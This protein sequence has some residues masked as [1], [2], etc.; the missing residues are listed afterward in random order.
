M[1][2]AP[3]VLLFSA[4]ASSAMAQPT[5]PGVVIDHQPAESRQYIGSPSILIAPNGDYLATH[6]LFGP[7]STSTVSAESKVFVSADR[8]ATWKETAHFSD[9]FWSNLFT[10]NGR[11]YLMGTTAEYGRILIRTSLDN[12]RTWSDPS[13]L[14]SDS[15]YHTAPVPVV[16]HDGRLY[17]AFEFHP[18]GPWGSF[19]AFMMSA[20]ITSNITRAESWTFSNRLSFPLSDEGN[21]WLEGNAVVTPT[22]QVVDI[23]RVNNRER[24]AILGLSGNELKLQQFVDFPGGAKKFSIRYDAKSKLY[25]ALV[26]PALPGEQISVSSPGSVRNTLAVVSSPDLEHWTPRSIVIHHPDVSHHGF[27]YVDWQ[28][29]GND[30]VVASR[31]AF[32]DAA[33][34]AHNFHDANFLTFHRIGNFRKLGTVKLTGEPF[35]NAEVV[36]AEQMR[37]W[38]DATTREAAMRSDKVASQ[39]IGRYETHTT[40]LTSRTATGAA[41]EHRDWCDIFVVVSGEATLVSG[42]QLTDAKTI[43]D[44]EKRGASIHGGQSQ[45]ITAGAVVHIDPGVPHQLQVEGAPFSYYVV[46]VRAR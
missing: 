24:A 9:Q 19:Q 25:W 16:I 33:G 39:Q 46:K 29:D 38:A 27:Q 42:G 40:T 14:T 44:G 41:E 10:L 20:P 35:H 2:L 36:S 3:F 31:T 12:G 45:K 6:D 4:I 18:T 11:I 22:G 23:L 15:G 26:N 21:T 37:K 7:G 32:D 17:R 34:G 30:L 1:R 43:S 5:P 28:F 8:G 13:Y